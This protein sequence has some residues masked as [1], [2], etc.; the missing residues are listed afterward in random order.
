MINYQI[1]VNELYIVIYSDYQAQ[2]E[3]DIYSESG[4]DDSQYSV[5]SPSAR[6][7]AERQMDRRDGIE[8]EADLF[9]SRV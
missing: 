4:M 7:A 8:N 6:R 5:L 1:L 2:P 9:Y 3:L